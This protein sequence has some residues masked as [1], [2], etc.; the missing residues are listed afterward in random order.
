MYVSWNLLLKDNIGTIDSVYYIEVS[1]N[2]E[3]VLYRDRGS[4]LRGSTV[5][6]YSTSYSIHKYSTIIKCFIGKKKTIKI[7]K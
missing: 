2:R 3:I 7:K 1:F 4:A 5:L 6:M